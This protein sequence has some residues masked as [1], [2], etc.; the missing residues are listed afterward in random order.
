MQV[1]LPDGSAEIIV[2]RGSPLVTPTGEPPILLAGLVAAPC[3]GRIDGTTEMVGVRLRP[4]AVRA[5]TGVPAHA[6]QGQHDA[7][8]VLPLRLREAL[9][10]V[11]A[12]PTIEGAV[13]AA[14]RAFSKVETRASDFV[15]VQFAERIQRDGCVSAAALDAVARGMGVSLRYVQRCFRDAVGVAPSTF[16]R[17]VRFRRAADAVFAGRSLASVASSVGYADQPHLTRE[18]R[19][20]AG[21]PPAAIRAAPLTLSRAF[22]ET[23]P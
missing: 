3:R 17:V 20:F 19:V 13:D 22:C 14:D 2:H 1:L 6:L 9:A 11:V 23:H 16:A 8:L 7:A 15:A 12:A 4:G 5:V 18:F 21:A 10:D